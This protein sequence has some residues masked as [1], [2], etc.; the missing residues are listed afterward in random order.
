MARR[1][2]LTKYS[3]IRDEARANGLKYYYTGT[4]CE[5]GHMDKRYVNTNICY[6]CKREQNH[7]DF[8]NHK[9]RV[10]D[11]C[12]KSY[13]RTK[14]KHIESSRQWAKNNRDRSNNIKHRWKI[15]HREQYL[16]GARRYTTYKCQDPFYRLNKRMSTAIWRSLKAGKANKRWENT[17]KFTFEE[18]KLHLESMFVEGMTW[19]NYGKVWSVDHIKP[20]V[21]CE[22]FEEA[23]QLSNL[24]PLFNSENARKRDKYPYDIKR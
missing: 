16:E 18:L 7:R 10:L 21:L 9:S 23:W 13:R 20:I 12:H 5:N 19:D 22:L 1:L 2:S 24:Q 15:N 6:A 17:V 3:N 8:I 11:N 14:T 4:I